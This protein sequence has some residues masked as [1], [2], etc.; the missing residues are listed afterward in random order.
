MPQ[1]T[2]SGP[3]NAK[4][5]WK[6]PV[7]S[8]LSDEKWSDKSVE[9][10]L[11]SV[12][13]ANPVLL[14]QPDERGMRPI[15][16]AAIQGSAN[17]LKVMLEVAGP[18]LAQGEDVLGLEHADDSNET[19]ISRNLALLQ[20]TPR[21]VI[22]EMLDNACK[23]MREGYIKCKLPKCVCGK[24]TAGWLSPRM[25]FRLR[26]IA[27]GAY[28]AML[29]RL[30]D[31]V[32]K[33]PLDAEAASDDPFLSFLPRRIVA[34]GIHREFYLGYRAAFHVVRDMLGIPDA[35]PT[36]TSLRAELAQ[37]AKEGSLDG[38]CTAWRRIV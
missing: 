29:S 10:M 28:I 6:F 30:D 33:K 18:Q 22:H 19:A 23:V 26:E 36:T 32:A 3:S 17:A 8:A 1:N 27:H 15:T 37:G 25:R 16:V 35:A 31:F 11:R 9:K 12:Y 13:K 20:Q 7:H 34:R 24:C 5:E 2:S 14:N 4:M 21:F 38:S